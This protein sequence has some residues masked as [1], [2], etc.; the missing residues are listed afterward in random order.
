MDAR[1]TVKPVPRASGIE[2]LR[3]PRG[4]W[5]AR[6]AERREPARR[7]RTNDGDA[8]MDLRAYSG[9]RAVRTDERGP[10]RRDRS[11][12][13]REVFRTKRVVSQGDIIATLL[14]QAT[15]PRDKDKDP[16]ASTNANGATGVRECGGSPLTADCSPAWDCEAESAF[17]GA[18]SG[19]EGPRSPADRRCPHGVRISTQRG[20]RRRSRPARVPSAPG[21][22]GRRPGQ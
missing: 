20:R 18:T 19:L 15:S 1:D 4:K 9:G 14:G 22:S 5:A 13:P 10:L 12:S 3:R 16:G 21:N 2:G 7:W 8:T 6:L 17:A 11:S